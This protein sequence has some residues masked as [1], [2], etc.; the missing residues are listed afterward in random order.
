MLAGA[1][2]LA[3]IALTGSAWRLSR[4][5][6]SVAK[7]A[8][9]IASSATSSPAKRATMRPPRI[10]STRWARARISS[11]SD[12]IRST[13][14]PVSASDTISSWMPELGAHVDPA[15]GLVQDQQ[16]RPPEQPLGEQHLLLVAARERR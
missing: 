16:P 12:E 2:P 6:G 8:C 1:S 11:I 15:R 14:M 7:A 10:T 3:V 4:S 5:P 13:A 9:R